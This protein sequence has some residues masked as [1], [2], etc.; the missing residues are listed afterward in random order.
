[1]YYYFLNNNK[2]KISVKIYFSH[3]N[4]GYFAHEETLS[5]CLS[6]LRTAVCNECETP[7]Q[8]GINLDD[9]QGFAHNFVSYCE[10]CDSKTI[11]FN[12]SKKTERTEIVKGNLTPFEVEQANLGSLQ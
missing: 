9:S 8:C 12:S 1:M 11:L 4:C 3:I 7:V 5:G 6:S 10:N 2:T